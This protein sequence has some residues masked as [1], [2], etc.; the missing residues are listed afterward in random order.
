VG[1]HARA[2]TRARSALVA[3]AL[4][5]LALAAA[6]SGAVTP[7]VQLARR[8]EAFRLPYEAVTFP[9]DGDSA[10][11]EGWWIRGPKGSSVF[12]LA[13]PDSGNR[14][15]LLPL[16][17][18]LRARGFSVLLFDYRDFGPRGAGPADSLRDIVFASRWVDDAVGA[19]RFARTHVDSGGKVIAWGHA[20]GSA[21]MVAALGR[22]RRIAAGLAVDNPFRSVDDVLRWNGT[23]GI[24]DVERRHRHL[25]KPNDEPCL[26]APRILVATL[27]VLA[28]R[29]ESAPA[30][31]ADAL[32]ARA[33]ARVD[34]FALPEASLRDVL[35]ARGYLDRLVEWGRWVAQ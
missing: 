8:P 17:G 25:V 23:S 35:K 16:A 34:R 22:E 11:L 13:G 1:T 20:L 21:V 32:F 30:A 24:P 4:A 12:V 10:T 7:S 28:G 33:R 31:A 2:L 9:A 6:P 15:D 27:L 26:A 5:A 19:L 29:D 3:A 18:D 14:A